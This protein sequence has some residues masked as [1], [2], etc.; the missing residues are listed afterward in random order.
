MKKYIAL[1]LVGFVFACAKVPITG[2]RQM[3]LLP[4]S[5][6]ITMA[7]AQYKEFLSQNQVMND[8]HAQMVKNVGNKISKAV[9]KYLKE[10]G[11]EKRIEGY[12]WEFNLVKD[13][14]INAWCMPG[15]KVVFYTGILPIAKDHTGIAVVM[16]HE[17]AHAIARHGNERMSQAL[18]IQLGGVTLA[19][20]TSQESEQTQNIFLQS[21]GLASTLGSLK[22]SRK[23]E[24]ESDKLGLVFMALAGYNPEAAIDFWERMSAQ[25]G[26]R[27]PEILSTHPHGETRIAEIKE[28]LPEAM[29]YYKGQ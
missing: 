12:Q 16:G 21:Y 5:E 25:S 3:K 26:V 23:H 10:N 15:G 27:P 7:N 29:K 14:L 2:R 13:S 11:H 20:A 6:L 8:N 24:S 28:Y 18:A 19:T 22:Y 17:I 4:E 9:E 1:F